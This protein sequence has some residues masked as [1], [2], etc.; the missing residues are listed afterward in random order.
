MGCSAFH[1]FRSANMHSRAL[2]VRHSTI[3]PD[4]LASRGS[5]WLVA[6]APSV[7]AKACSDL[8]QPRTESATSVIWAA[9]G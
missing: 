8:W 1:N 5:R 9:A 7:Q 4:G 6:G 3:A 2:K